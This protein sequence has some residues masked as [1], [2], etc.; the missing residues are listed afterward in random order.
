MISPTWGDKRISVCKAS[1]TPLKFCRPLSAP[2]MR[3]PRPPARMTPVMASMCSGA[4]ISLFTKSTSDIAHFDTFES[5][6]CRTG[7]RR[8][9]RAQFRITVGA[10]LPDGAHCRRNLLV[11][12]VAP[13]QGAK[14]MALAGKQAQK[15]FAF[16]GEPGPVAVVTKSLC[17]AADHADFTSTVGIAPALGG[18]AQVVRV[19]GREGELGIEAF[20]DLL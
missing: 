15:K 16:G 11:G 19:D 12:V 6:V 3:E 2:P 17:H 18:F 14:I 20:N 10:R 9:G 7:I 1:G 8:Q 4:L 13:Q 5:I